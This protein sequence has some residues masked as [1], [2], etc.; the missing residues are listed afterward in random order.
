MKRHV[1]RP[2]VARRAS[3]LP[4]LCG[5]LIEARA[6]D[7]MDVLLYDVVSPAYAGA[8]LKQVHRIDAG[9]TAWGCL[10]RLCGGLIEALAGL[11][12]QT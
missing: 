11:G 10:P 7:V 9:H 4:R 8:S 5:G 3:C 2:A 1:V 12:Q 6:G